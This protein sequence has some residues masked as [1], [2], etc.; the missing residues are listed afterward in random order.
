MIGNVHFTVSA[1]FQVFVTFNTKL[2]LSIR[3]TM[4]INAVQRNR[5][6]DIG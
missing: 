1:Q 5:R 2:Y 4:T 6:I 3:I